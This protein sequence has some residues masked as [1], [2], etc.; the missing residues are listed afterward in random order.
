MTVLMS[1]PALAGKMTDWIKGKFIRKTEKAAAPFWTKFPSYDDAVKIAKADTNDGEKFLKDKSVII[2]HEN[3]I[4]VIAPPHLNREVRIIPIPN[5]NELLGASLQGLKDSDGSMKAAISSVRARREVKV[6]QRTNDE[7]EFITIRSP[8]N[9]SV[10][11]VIRWNAETGE[12]VSASVFTPNVIYKM[13]FV[14]DGRLHLEMNYVNDAEKYAHQA[15]HNLYFDMSPG[16]TLENYTVSKQGNFYLKMKS[17]EGVVSFRNTD[18]PTA[19]AS[20]K[21]VSSPTARTQ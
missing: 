5:D 2:T 7:T 21:P 18:S 8:S 10:N 3:K 1:Y 19:V 4:Y 14:D 13:R 9:E 20:V 17:K 6:N 15:E 12:F 16:T 11:K